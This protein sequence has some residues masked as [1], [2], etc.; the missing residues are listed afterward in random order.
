MMFVDAVY[1]STY[2][3]FSLILLPQ[4]DLMTPSLPSACVS[5]SK[6]NPFP[7]NQV[8]IQ[9]IEDTVSPASPDTVLVMCMAKVTIT[10]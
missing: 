7:G 2:R 5:P 1:I 6:H 3:N 9:G 10:C 8:Y 4:Q